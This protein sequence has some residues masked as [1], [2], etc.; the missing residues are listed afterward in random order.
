MKKVKRIRAIFGFMFIVFLLGILPCD[1]VNAGNSIAKNTSTEWYIEDGNYAPSIRYR[2]NYGLLAK[3]VKSVDAATC[4]ST[5]SSA[6]FI[7]QRKGEYR[8]IDFSKKYNLPDKNG[9]YYKNDLVADHADG[10]YPADTT[11]LFLTKGGKELLFTGKANSFCPSGKKSSK[12]CCESHALKNVSVCWSDEGMLACIKDGALR[13]YEDEYEEDEEERKDRTKKFFEGKTDRIRKVVSCVD[14][15][16]GISFFVLMKDGTVWGMGGNRCHIISDDDKKYYSDFV[17]LEVK[18]V[19]D[20][21][22]AGKNVGVLKKDG[23]LW[24][25]G[26]KQT[27]KDAGKKEF[28]AKPWRI[29]KGV[30][31]FSMAPNGPYNCTLLFVK[32]SKAYGWGAASRYALPKNSKNNGYHDRPVYLKSNIKRVY[33]ASNMTLLLDNAG[34]LYWQGTVENPVDFS[35]VEK[36]LTKKKS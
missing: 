29:E 28:T 6:V 12:D 34:N 5:Q 10:F 15:W 21:C 9:I 4:S 27:G 24:V 19:K 8:S 2:K 11:E 32:N 22:A 25:W 7:S 26:K 35:W 23:S 16:H 14:Y 20:I 3:N 30:Q 17:K 1:I 18:N 33:T 36:K 31:S 13:I